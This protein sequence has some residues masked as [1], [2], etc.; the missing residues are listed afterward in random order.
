MLILRVDGSRP[1]NMNLTV[2][3]KNVFSY[4]MFY[5]NSSSSNNNNNNNYYYYY[6]NIRSYIHT[7]FYLSMK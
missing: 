7:Y 4:C 5:G 1:M 2:V 6:N 3:I